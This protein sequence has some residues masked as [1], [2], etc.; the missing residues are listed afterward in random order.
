MNE[1]P[2]P[3]RLYKTL[4]VPANW[5]DAEA[6][7]YYLQM[8]WRIEHTLIVPVDSTD[9]L[10]HQAYVKYQDMLSRTK[11]NG[12]IIPVGLALL[13]VCVLMYLYIGR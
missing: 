12:Y 1:F 4:S 8:L 11:N 7:E 9:P 10:L 5:N 2:E 13:V 6:E 3:T